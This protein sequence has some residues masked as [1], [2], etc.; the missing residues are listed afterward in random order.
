MLKRNLL[1]IV[2]R[3]WLMSPNRR[4]RKGLTSR[5]PDSLKV[6]LCTVNLTLLVLLEVIRVAWPSSG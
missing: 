3:R 5:D 6:Y 2:L 4:L 1:R